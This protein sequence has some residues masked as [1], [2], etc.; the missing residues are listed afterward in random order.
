M[1]KTK[2][3]ILTAPFSQS[4]DSNAN[5]SYTNIIYYLFIKTSNFIIP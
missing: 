4:R 3:G 5:K 1:N 2:V